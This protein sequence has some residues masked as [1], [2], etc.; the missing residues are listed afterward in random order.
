MY[1]SAYPL[2]IILAVDVLSEKNRL[3]QVVLD[4]LAPI[5]ACNQETKIFPVYVLQVDPDEE[6]GARDI[7]ATKKAI[8]ALLSQSSLPGIQK[9]TILTQSTSRST[10]D[11]LTQYARDQRADLIAAGTKG[12]L[13]EFTKA[14]IPRCDIPVYVTH[15]NAAI[16]S[17]VKKVLF[18]TDFREGSHR[19]FLKFLSLSKTMDATI[20]LLYAGKKTKEAN[21]IAQHWLEEAGQLGLQAEFV[22]V[23]IEQSL[24]QTLK[25]HS[26][27]MKMD[28]IAIP[29][30]RSALGAKLLGSTALSIVNDIPLP[31][32]VLHI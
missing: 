18:P 12:R 17:S 3:A 27:S 14:L 7:A 9:P 13:G 11:S 2:K 16:H 15:Q 20:T 24:I 23:P 4:S 32:C 31:I 8:E 22:N 25:N 26:Q 5:V 30:E 6:Q 28:L 10:V 19:A 1:Q 21:S 29:T